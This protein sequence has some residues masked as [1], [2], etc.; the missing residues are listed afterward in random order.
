MQGLYRRQ[1]AALV[2]RV[3]APAQVQVGRG[4]GHDADAGLAQLR[5][6]RLQLRRVERAQAGHVTE[7]DAALVAALDGLARDVVHR[8]KALV[9][10]VVGKIGMHVDR[11]VIALRQLEHHVD[12]AH[13]IGPVQLVVRAAADH[14]RAHV[15]G[16]DHQLA[17]ALR[18]QDALLREGHDLQVEQVLVLGLE[19][20]QR[21]HP[22]QALDQVDVGMGA[23]RDGAMP[24]RHVQHLARAVQHVVPL[25]LAF[26][27]AGDADGL[28]QRAQP[29][30]Q[31]AMQQRL[32]QV[33]VRFHQAR[34]GGAAAGFDHFV[35]RRVDAGF[36]GGNAPVADGDI[37]QGR[38]IADARVPDQQI[39]LHGV[40]PQVLSFCRSRC[41][42]T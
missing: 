40:S 16:L 20:Q 28:V 21:L 30:G 4:Q 25:L 27:D 17:R 34:D 36:D 8:G 41:P 14:V 26:Q 13:G 39:Q 11:R 33:Q 35:R 1:P 5:H 38:V 18:L 29:G 23:D 24:D 10:G 3:L 6:Q 15:H 9:G 42:V 31:P 12:M 32:V 2:L 37:G 19:L 7:R 22:D